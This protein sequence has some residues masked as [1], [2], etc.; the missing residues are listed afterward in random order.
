M[1]L[2]TLTCS[3]FFTL[4][5]VSTQHQHDQTPVK[6]AVL[7]S[8]LGRHHH[9]I[10]T[11]N[12]E[13]Q[14]FFDQGLNLVYAF[15]HEE[16][17]RSF[18]RAAELDPQAAMPHWGVALALGPNINSEIDPARERAAYGAAQKAVQLAGRAPENERAYIHALAKRY[19]KDSNADLNKLAL[20]Y[21]NAMS[22]LVRRY[23]DD[24]DAA[25]LYAESMMDLR[26]WKMWTLDGKP[27]P[28]TEEIVTV[29][30][31]VLKRDPEHPGANH[32]YI[33]AVESSRNPERALP[34]ARRLGALAPS[35]GHLV[36]MPSHIYVQTGDY[37]EAVK[38]NAA[39]AEADRT[40]IQSTGAK[41][42]YPLMYYSHN[43]HFLAYANA[44][45]GKFADAQKAAGQLVENVAPSVSDMPMLEGWIPTPIFVLLRFN[46]WDDLLR[47]P[48]PDPKLTTTTV[49]WRFARGVAYAVKGEIRNAE[50][51]RRA[52]DE[53]Q[54]QIG[55]DA[56]FGLLNSA[57]SVLRV[58]ALVLDARI[59]AAKSDSRGAIDLWGKAVE[60][61]EG[62]AYDEP[63]AWYY[64]VRESLGAA[65][66][67]NG[68][69]QEAEGV[70]RRDLERNPRNGRSLF[71]LW[72][73]LKS[74]NKTVDADWVRRQFEAA[75]KNSD[76]RL[77]IEDL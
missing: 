47:L 49:V 73:S 67:Q 72:Q 35:A 59:A 71:G 39:A 19:S 8:G 3:I 16:A 46:R 74:Q 13:A 55:E 9:P 41:G 61:Q 68:R 44:A 11:N 69:Y 2:F 51:E 52:F 14:A 60:A 22:E 57:S 4:S 10:S 56:M 76:I 23:P 43:L 40:Y 32:Y 24:L 54:K 27:A 77:R 50:G 62:L 6:A 34:S 66:L 21:K 63:P 1:M 65:L 25:T 5:S 33:H 26:P 31:S 28:G 53:A 20:D 38:S 58:A 7:L 18:Q 30:E 36:H 29:L 48:A 70:F 12:R 15:N 37:D 75:W 45:L 64:P 42:M 17:T